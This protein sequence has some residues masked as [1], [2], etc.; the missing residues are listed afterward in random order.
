MMGVDVPVGWSWWGL[1]DFELDF[2]VLCSGS[3]G[4]WGGF[5]VDFGGGWFM[6]VRGRLR[7]GSRWVCGVVC[8]GGGFLVHSSGVGVCFILFFMLSQTLQNIFRNIF[9]ECNK[10]KKKKI[11]EIICIWKHF[12][13]E[14][15]L[16][17]NKWSL[18]FPNL[19][20]DL[21]QIRK[22]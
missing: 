1:V 9:L 13:L 18:S 7:G 4:L 5:L 19:K 8:W 21:S 2:L 17:R 20:I 11:P 6:V 3:R 16:Q 15:I 10:K 12:A 14:N 22:I